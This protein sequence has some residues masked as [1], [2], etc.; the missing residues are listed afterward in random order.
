MFLKVA[1]QRPCTQ[2]LLQFRKE[3]CLLYVVVMV[4]IINLKAG[5]QFD[6]IYNENVFGVTTAR[7][8]IM[9]G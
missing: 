1:R 3:I 2:L 6:K 5:D 4:N 7:Q 9:N 8:N